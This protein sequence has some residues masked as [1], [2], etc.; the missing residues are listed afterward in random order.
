VIARERSRL[1]VLRVRGRYGPEPFT[2]CAS[3]K[4]QEVLKATGR[5][6]RPLVKSEEKFLLQDLRAG[7]GGARKAQKRLEAFAAAWARL[8]SDEPRQ[9]MSAAVMR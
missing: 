9:G 1:S 7:F 2:A 3:R 8:Q 6:A 4:R 5:V